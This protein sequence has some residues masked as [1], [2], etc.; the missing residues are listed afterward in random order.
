F[1]WNDL[2]HSPPPRIPSGGSNLGKRLKIALPP[3]DPLESAKF[4]GLRYVTGE[5][6]G[7]VR[8]RA[9]KGFTYLG[10]DS[11][12]LRDQATLKRIASLVIPPAWKNVWICPVE[13]GHIQAIGRDAKGRK[14]YRYHPRYR[15]VRDEAKYGRM[16]LFGS[17]LPR[18]RARVRRDLARE[19][20]PR[21]RV[22]GALVRLLETTLARVGNVEY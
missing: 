3:T 12:P 20:L 15:E 17:V 1:G 6:P 19:G 10:V 13:N 22:L 14:Q 18:I 8:R 11:K 7:I 4:A 21:E 16:L 2:K 5:G 9:G